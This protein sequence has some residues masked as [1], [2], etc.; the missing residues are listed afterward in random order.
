MIEYTSCT[1]KG[2][3]KPINEDCVIIDN[4][5]LYEGSCSGRIEDS[6]V[7]VVCDGVGGEPG[8]YI[9]SR[10][11]ASSFKSTQFIMGSPFD[12]CR[13]LHSI[14]YRLIQEQK[15]RPEFQSMSTTIAGMMISGSQYL[16]WSLGDTRIYELTDS[17]SLKHLTRDNIIIDSRQRKYVTNYLG[18]DGNA[19]DP[20]VKRG[21]IT[22]KTA[23]FMVC[24][25]GVYQCLPEQEIISIL[26]SELNLECK[27]KAIMQRA[28]H[29]GS[30][31]DKSL[32]LL[33]YSV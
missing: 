26:V 5:I 7:A 21:F 32:I 31:D 18:A 17:G 28:L 27:R 4:E 1:E 33:S 23:L 8:G 16:L 3:L 29:Y 15:L 6:I 24:S 10:I 9:A 30:R 13:H 22:K 12:L 19:C 25:D 11:A 20:V 14:N 2:N